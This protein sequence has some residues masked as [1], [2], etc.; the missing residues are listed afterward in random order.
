MPRPEEELARRGKRRCSSPRQEKLSSL[1]GKGRKEAPAWPPVG[2]IG[3]KGV[4]S[5][6]ES[7]TGQNRNCHTGHGETFILYGGNIKQDKCLDGKV[8]IKIKT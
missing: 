4:G 3:E 2:S 7:G 8:A 5:R 6:W 1:Q